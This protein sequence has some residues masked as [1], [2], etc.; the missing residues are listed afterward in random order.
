MSADAAREAARE[1]KQP[2]VIFDANEVERMTILP[3]PFIG[4]YRPKGWK[5][6]DRWLCD[7]SGL[8]ADYEPALSIRQLKAKLSAHTAS[9]TEYG[10]AVVEAGQFQVHLGVFERTARVRATRPRRS[11]GPALS[12]ARN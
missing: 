10:Y 4:S 11:R 7:S 8:G 3:F 1:H 6:V 12:I 2:Y 9:A 5:V